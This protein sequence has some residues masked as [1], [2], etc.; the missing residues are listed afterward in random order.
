M[1]RTEPVHRTVVVVDVEGYGDPRRTSPNRVAVRDRMYQALGEGFAAAGVPWDDCDTDDSGDGVLVLV[2]ATISKAPLVERMPATVAASLREHNETHPV[3]E[4]VRMRMAIHAGEITRDVNGSTGDCL[5]HAARLCDAP[6]LKT[7]LAQS[8]GTLALILSSWMYDEIARHCTQVDPATFRPARVVVKETDTSAWIALPDHPYPPNQAPRG[9]TASGPRQLPAAPTGFVGRAAESTV[10]DKQATGGGTMVISTLAGAGGIGKTCLAVHWAHQNL[11][12]YPDGQLF[13]DLQGFSPTG[14]PL[15]PPAVLRGFLEALGEA[16]DRIPTDP[17]NLARHYRSRIA[18]KQMLILLDNAATVDQVWDL[19][20]GT[21]TC[22]VLVTSRHRLAGLTALHGARPLGLDVLP[23]NDARALM[24][25]ALGPDRLA[26]EP[27]AVAE[28][29][30]ICAGLPLAVR[31]VTARAAQCPDFPLAALA[32]DLRDATARLDG[33]AAGDQRTNLLAVLSWSIRHLPAEAQTVF[34]LLGAAPGPDI[35]LCAASALTGLPPRRTR[36]LLQELEDVSLVRQPTPGRYRMHDL[37]RIYARKQD[38]AP[39][40]RAA[41]LG[42]VLDFY[43]S[44]AHAA[45]R[46]L[47]PNRPPITLDVPAFD[48]PSAPLPDV[49]AAL[50]WFDTEHPALLAAQQIATT[51]DWH[52]SRWQLAWALDTFHARRGNRGDRLPMWRA[53]LD[54]ADHLPEAAARIHA[55]RRYGG[56]CVDVGQWDEGIRHLNQALALAEEHGETEQQAHTH[57]GLTVLWA[58]RGE[59]GPALQHALRARILFHL[60]QQTTEEAS[61]LNA[62]GW[63][64]TELGDHAKANQHCQAALALLRDHPDAEVEA[65]TLDS[66]GYIAHRSGHHRD[67][68]AYYLRSL[69]LFRELGNN[70][71]AAGT[72][73][74]LGR[75]HVDLGERDQARAAWEEALQLHRA[76]GHDGAADRLQQQLGEL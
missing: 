32:E 36:A 6:A 40:V 50:A 21:P 76:Q 69:A 73:D 34:A 30:D 55:H 67:A 59:H 41:A 57:R 71:E 25:H 27:R 70:S 8:P 51:H 62:M 43:V 35:A 1:S 29:L 19:L 11:H 26:A 48:G 14:T 18:D 65:A 28:L 46:I 20:P 63:C 45:D 10:L 38:L 56:V 3:E 74:N 66:L 4:R 15:E 24:A 23:T 49:A 37:I 58:S 7:A 12:R 13:V 16:P 72:L 31:I 17:Q 64:A 33:L 5:I 9:V 68:V 60:L 39:D 44:T 22:T 2:P 54:A 75:T 42:R 52:R 61:M 53:A 47:D